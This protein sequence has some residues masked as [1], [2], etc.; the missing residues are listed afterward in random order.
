MIV[1]KEIQTP[2]GKIRGFE[3]ET[4]LPKAKVFIQ[5]GY[6]S[7]NH[8]G[9]NRMY[10]QIADHLNKSGFTVYR[11][12]CIG[13]GDSDGEFIDTSY[14]LHIE[15]N[16]S[17]IN[18]FKKEGDKI[19]FIGHSMGTSVAV[20]LATMFQPI[21]LVLISP[22]LGKINYIENLFSSNQLNELETTGRTERKGLIASNQFM[23]NSQDENIFE[24]CKRLKSNVQIHYGLRDELYNIE[25]AKYAT[26]ILNADLN[27]YKNSD[28]NFLNIHDR[29]DMIKK[30]IEFIIKVCN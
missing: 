24:L 9:P 23:L 16:I 3:H 2:K 26:N 20:R 6:F 1:Y 14:Q 11:F 18:S 12:A 15:N 10:W 27:C 29:E 19:V 30:L 4:L 7:S 22:S 21:S 28:H 17:L 8:L 5:H 13:M 25:S